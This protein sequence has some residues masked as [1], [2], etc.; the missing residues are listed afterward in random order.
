MDADDLALFEQSLRRAN[1]TC[2]GAALDDALV[3][4]GWHDALAADP[5]AAI[6]VHFELQGRAA[7]TSSALDH[8]VAG[9]LG[10]EAVAVVLP[11]LGRCEPPGRDGRV[12][13]VGTAVVTGAERVLVASASG[14]QTVVGTVATSELTLSPI[15]GIDPD[16]GLARVSGEMPRAVE[17]TPAD[18]D[19]AVDVARL[20]IAHELVGASRT[21]LDQARA[22]A[23]ERVQFGRPIAAFQAVRHRLAESLVAVEAAAAVIDA[24]W[25]DR[26]A[27][28]AA[29][30]KAVA[31]RSARTV[32]KHCQQVLAGIGFTTEHPFHRSL[33]RVLVLDELFGASRTLTTALGHDVLASG[34]L[35]PLLPL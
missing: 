23:V 33:R 25:L 29:M 14:G 15:A 19:A 35:P 5:R 10:V 11:A 4:L 7:A 24:A 1:E 16:L 27:A 21:M 22:H 9:A 28:N 20:A 6:A 30:A 17:A 18:W 31:G 13:G 2:T 12:D 34:H 3:D 8:V 26:T 32:A